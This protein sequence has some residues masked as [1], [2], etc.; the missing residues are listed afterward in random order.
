[1]KKLDFEEIPQEPY[2]MQKNG[3]ICFFHL[4]DI[5][6]AFHKDTRNEIERSVASLPKALI[7]E[8]KRRVKWFLGLLLIR[9]R[10]EK[11]WLLLQKSIHYEDL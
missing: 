3:I 5:V 6:F 2:M 10:S 4:D 9:D 8:R 1:M 7:I 11:A